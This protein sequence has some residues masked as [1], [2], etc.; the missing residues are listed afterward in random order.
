MPEEGGGEFRGSREEMDQGTSKVLAI[1]KAARQRPKSSMRVGRV[2]TR[3]AGG[4]DKPTRVQSKYLESGEKV[5]IAQR[6]GALIP[7]PEILK[8][9]RKVK[10]QEVGEKDTTG[11]DSW[12]VTY[13]GDPTKRW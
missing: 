2:L 1:R 7:R 4:T 11:E 13:D 9:R 12:E 10:S 8:Q 6:S 3:E 5:R